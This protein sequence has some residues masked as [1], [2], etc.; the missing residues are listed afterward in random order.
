MK[1]ALMILALVL[2]LAAV[3]GEAE[4]KIIEIT[5]VP[6]EKCKGTGEVKERCP[7]CRGRK[8][9]PVWVWNK[10]KK[11][12][13]QEHIPC[14]SCEGTGVTPFPVVC[15]KCRGDKTFWLVR[16][17]RERKLQP[18]HKPIW[19]LRTLK[20]NAQRRL[21]GLA[22][23]RVAAEYDIRCADEGIKALTEEA[24]APQPPE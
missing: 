6:C 1:R 22:A 24:E 20:L 10:Q 8:I 18:N 17:K 3:A 9:I 5:K 2:P 11:E 23:I 7:S 16:G 19:R 12:I 4:K 14:P 13:T 21:A 15:P